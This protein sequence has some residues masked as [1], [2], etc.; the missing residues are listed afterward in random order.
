MKQGL[1]T[2]RNDS[3]LNETAS[4]VDPRPGSAAPT[5]HTAAF[6]TAGGHVCT[7]AVHR[8][9]ERSCMKPHCWH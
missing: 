3:T 1:E 6:S 4:L 7:Q 2:T 5:Q 8:D 9:S